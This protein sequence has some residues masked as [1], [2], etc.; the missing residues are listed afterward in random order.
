MGGERSYVDYHAWL[1]DNDHSKSNL[2]KE[3][4]ALDELSCHGSVEVN[5]TP[6]DEVALNVEAARITVGQEPKPGRNHWETDQ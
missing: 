4:D 1:N 6:D 3:D 2:H 5:A